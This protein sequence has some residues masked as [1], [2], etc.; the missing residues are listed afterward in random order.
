MRSVRRAWTPL[1]IV[2]LNT[3]ALLLAVNAVT[4]V[5]LTTYDAY[6]AFEPPIRSAYPNVDLTRVYPGYSNEDIDTLLSEQWSQTHIYE[7]FT[8]HRELPRNSRYINVAPEGYRLNGVGSPTW[9]PPTNAVTVFVFGGSTTFGV[10][11][12]DASTI[13]AHLA[14]L[15]HGVHVYNFGRR[16]YYSSQER[17]LLEELLAKGLVPDLAIFIDGLN[18]FYGPTPAYTGRLSDFMNGRAPTTSPLDQFAIVR[19]VDRVR[20]RL[21]PR[22]A[23]ENPQPSGIAVASALSRYRANRR[24]IQAVAQA[25]NTETLFVW[26]PV[27]SY[28]Y[29][30]TYHLFRSQESAA[31]RGYEAMA[32]TRGGDD[33]GFL[34]LADLQRDAREPLYVDSVHYTAAFAG[35]IAEHIARALRERGLPAITTHP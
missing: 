25:F 2:L 11:V 21:L 17:S 29:D 24:M 33:V 27:P 6:S 22:T 1:A 26:Q 7:P 10:G 23:T 5:A 20:R 15:L 16:F 3:V 13:P 4:W 9:P 19:A 35:Q 8:E 34:W 32:A 28:G 30:L 31:Q 14:R 12:E 18:E